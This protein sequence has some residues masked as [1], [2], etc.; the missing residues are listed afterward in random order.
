MQVSAILLAGGRGKRMHSSTP[1]VLH[2]VAGRPLLF[3]S[4]KLLSQLP[5]NDVQVVIG[6]RKD[7]VKGV[8]LE[9]GHELKIDKK[10]GFSVLPKILGTGYAVD[11]TLKN[12][13]PEKLWGILAGQ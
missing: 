3:Y 8:A 11:V 4:L 2:K 7:T 5:I 9:I 13:K 10:I 1:K 6:Y 12:V